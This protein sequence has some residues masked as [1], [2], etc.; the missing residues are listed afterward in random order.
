MW[1]DT[2]KSL[3]SPVKPQGT[4]LAAVLAA[5]KAQV[6]KPYLFGGKWDLKDPNPKGGIDCSGLM[7]WCW[8]QGANI[9][10]PDGSV[11]QYIACNPV[12][13]ARPTDMGFFKYPDGGSVYHVGMLFDAET[14]LEA[15]AQQKDALGNLIFNAVILRP[16]SK[17]EAW[18]YFTGWRRLSVLPD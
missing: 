7:R 14:V 13:L 6:G 5:G 12:S 15:R 1:L 3:L 16:R 11:S 10:I 18:K 4:N 2:L 8:A 17:W 9:I